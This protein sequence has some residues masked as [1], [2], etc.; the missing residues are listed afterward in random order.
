MVSSLEPIGFSAPKFSSDSRNLGDFSISSSS[1]Y[2]L[3]CPAQ[4]SPP[5]S[6]RWNSLANI[7]INLMCLAVIRAPSQHWTHKD[8]FLYFI[9]IFRAGGLQWSQVCLR[10]Q[11]FG[12]LFCTVWLWLQPELPGTVLTRKGTNTEYLYEYEENTNTDTETDTETKRDRNLRTKT[13]TESQ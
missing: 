13:E 8:T 10:F 4:A 5:P 12:L 3:P 2:N 11:A 7:M 6:V 1:S 9:S